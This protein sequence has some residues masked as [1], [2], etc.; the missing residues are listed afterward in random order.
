[1][2]FLMVSLNVFLQ[3][4]GL[5]ASLQALGDYGGHVWRPL[6]LSLGLTRPSRACTASGGGFSWACCCSVLL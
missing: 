1:M 5:G 4:E 6:L 3:L 2:A